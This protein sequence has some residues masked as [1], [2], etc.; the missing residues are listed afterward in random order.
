M[1]V[2]SL[3]V[4]LWVGDFTFLCFR[5]FVCKMDIMRVFIFEYDLVR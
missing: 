5:F 1:W 3:V 2:F 4:W